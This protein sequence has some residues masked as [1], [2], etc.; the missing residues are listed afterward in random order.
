MNMVN[1]YDDTLKSAT[2]HPKMR[3]M[4]TYN[5]NYKQI[6][7]SRKIMVKSCRLGNAA[8]SI[9][10]EAESAEEFHQGTEV[11][12]VRPRFRNSSTSK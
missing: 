10:R 12:A 1:N 9:C 4:S 7:Q 6:N 11:S 2:F 8:F 5:Q 3:N